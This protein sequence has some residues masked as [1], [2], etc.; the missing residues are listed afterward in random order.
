MKTRLLSTAPHTAR[1]QL[2]DLTGPLTAIAAA[3]PAR[4][5]AGTAGDALR[6]LEIFGLH[7]ARL[8]IRED[9]GRMNASL[10]EIL[11]ALGY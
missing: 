11:R 7:G 6:Q 8:D 10:G 5:C 1:I 2:E 3:C 9:A 4:D